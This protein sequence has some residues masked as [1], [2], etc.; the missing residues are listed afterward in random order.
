MWLYVIAV[1]IDT[2]EKYILLILQ[3]LATLNKRN[4]ADIWKDVKDFVISKDRRLDTFR[5]II[6]NVKQVNAVC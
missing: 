2:D 1:C 4:R 6:D 3:L 5:F